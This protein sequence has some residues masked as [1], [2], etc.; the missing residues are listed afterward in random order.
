MEELFT[1]VIKEVDMGLAI[2]GKALKISDPYIIEAVVSVITGVGLRSRVKEQLQLCVHLLEGYLA[3]LTSNPAYLLDDLETLY[4]YGE[5]QLGMTFDRTIL[6]KNKHEQWE[7]K[8][9]T[10]YRL[11]ALYDYDYE[12]FNIRPLIEHGWKRE[13]ILKSEEVHGMLLKRVL[14]YGYD[15]DIYAEIQKKEDEE[16]KYRQSLRL[17]YGEK[18]GRSAVMELYGWLIVNGRLKG[19]YK[20]TLR[21]DIIEIDPS[22]PRIREK[23]T[24]VSQSLLVRD[25]NSLPDWATSSNVD[26][27]ENL[28]IT[29]L[30]R[31]KGE[32]VMLRGYFEQRMDEKHSNIYMSGLSELIPS[33]MSEDEAS[34]Y[35]VRDGRDYNHAFYGEMGWRHLEE[36]EEYKEDWPLPD[37]LSHYSFSE[38][39]NERFKYQSVYLLNE[40]IT[41]RVGLVFD[42]VTMEYSAD[43]EVVSA[44]YINDTDQFFFIR[45]DVMDRILKA[46]HG[47]IRHHLYERRMVNEKLPK[48]V[49]EV[50]ERFVQHEKDLFYG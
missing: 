40:E 21:S 11:Y 6:Y 36:T 7:V 31:R 48:D 22:F 10:G 41:K 24:L 42:I 37:L 17:G 16:V 45:R 13:P 50:K 28:F 9:T 5:H 23:R 32:W 12:K 30:P 49:A 26:L 2:C 25:V 1:L 27:M 19:E 43:G 46:Y 47:K 38:W 15:E 33:D 29:K 3:L 35:R 14:D 34:S 20:N 4:S 44:H 8:S 39:S 18:L